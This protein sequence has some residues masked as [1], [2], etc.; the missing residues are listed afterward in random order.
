[1]RSLNF[2]ILDNP[3]RYRHGCHRDLGRFVQSDRLVD[4]DFGTH[5]RLVRLCGHRFAHGL[6]RVL[7][8]HRI[9]CIR[10]GMRSL[11]FDIL[12]NPSHHRHGCHCDHGRSVRSADPVGLCFGIL[13]HL[14]HLYDRPFDRLFQILCYALLVAFWRGFLLRHR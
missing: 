8:V 5:G 14:G 7:W 2:D 9:G 13:R 4:L 12:D 1:M 3:S 11:N 10:F 6:H